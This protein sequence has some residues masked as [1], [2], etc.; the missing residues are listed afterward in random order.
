MN[1][2][3]T[4]DCGR[5]WD[6]V[7]KDEGFRGWGV[8]TSQERF[9]K[10]VQAGDILLH[11]INR[12][13]A[14]AGYSIVLDRMQP[15]TSGSQVDREAHPKVIPIKRQVWLTRDQS[16]LTV[17][18]AGLSPLHYHRKPSF[19][20]INSTDASL[21]TTAIDAVQTETSTANEEFC[22]QWKF[23]S[24]GFYWTIT[25]NNAEGKCWLCKE[26]AA[27]W[28]EKHP[29]IA[30]KGDELSQVLFSFV[31]VAH[32][33]ARAHGGP[34]TPENVRALCP[35][36]HHIVDLLSPERKTEL[37]AEK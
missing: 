30:L 21:I 24:D 26:T 18:I 7:L 4:Q 2:H 27:T 17:G 31:E 33:Q 29:Q 22:E 13:R 1:F 10:N 32:I 28:I 36:C 34:I 3:I 8:A 37:L 5:G 20:V 9:A 6:C 16:A 19:T 25:R 15:N 23:G 14:W 11:Y 35:T 12:P